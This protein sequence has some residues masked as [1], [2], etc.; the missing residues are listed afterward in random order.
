ML[1]QR[2]KLDM[3]ADNIA[4]A[5]TNG[6]K[7]LGMSFEEVISRKQTENVASFTH[8][9]GTHYDF[10]QGGLTRTDNDLDVS[11]VGA[12]FFA[13]ERGGQIH[14]TRNGNFGLSPEGNLITDS[15]APVLD[16]NGGAINIPNDSTKITITNDG[17]IA[18]QN[19]PIATLGIFNIAEPQ[20]LIR[21]GNHGY[22]YEGAEPGLS[23]T[24]SLSQGYIENANINPIEETV[25]LTE[26]NRS[27]TSSQ[28]LV[29]TLEEL[30]QRAI[31]DLSRLPQ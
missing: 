29:K 2:S 10:A 8:H 14:Y 13:T 24:A 16:T 5:N 18:N 4:N 3:V 15:G 6:F 12:G 9:M 1:G 20:K 19:G 31:R 17:L 7:K 27:Y 28:K 21:T 30:E 23:T 22:I 26:I 25:N 11:I